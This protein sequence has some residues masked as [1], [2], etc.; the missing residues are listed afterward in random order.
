MQPPENSLPSVQTG[1]LIHSLQI[2]GLNV[3][4]TAWISIADSIRYAKLTLLSYK[5]TSTL[6]TTEVNSSGFF[7][8]EAV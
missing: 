6:I 2:S 5:I 8:Y 7:I 4:V 3:E 1:P